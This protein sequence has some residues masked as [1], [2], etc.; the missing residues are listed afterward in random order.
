MFTNMTSDTISNIY[1]RAIS[2]VV[3]VSVL[4]IAFGS[5]GCLAADPHR[6]PNNN[7]ASVPTTIKTYPNDTVLLPCHHSC[8][9]INVYNN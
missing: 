3:F 9:F 2:L 1:K 6:D 8:E 4:V 5:S 7:F